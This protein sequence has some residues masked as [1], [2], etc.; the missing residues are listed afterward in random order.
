MQ[1][2][3]VATVVLLM[4]AAMAAIFLAPQ[5]ARAQEAKP[6]QFKASDGVTVYGVY[7]AAQSSAAPVILLFHQA[8]SNHFEYAGIAPKLVA[9]GFSCLAIDQRRGGAM[10]GRGNETVR[11]QGHA[12]TAA[13]KVEDLEADLG[14]ALVWARARD[15]H[16]KVILWGS[17]YSASLVFVVA[18]EHPDEVAGVLAFSPGEYFEDQPTLAREAAS[19]VRV[20]VFVTSENDADALADATRIFDAVGSP[21]KVHYK[22]KFAVHG[23]STLRADRNPKGA[24]ANWQAVMKFLAQFEK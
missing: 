4:A 12:E 24:A 10:W 14:A 3:S 11:K 20:P 9:A 16:R 21:D 8:G 6:I 5:T 1:K 17:S 18:A 19:K 13:G 15:P 7:Y 23:S 22:A 2:R